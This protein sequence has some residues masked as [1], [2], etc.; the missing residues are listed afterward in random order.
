M[1]IS[2]L[3]QDLKEKALEYQRNNL[4]FDKESDSL[5][6]AFNWENTKEG[7]DFWRDLFL[8]QQKKQKTQL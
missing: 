8:K 1:K 7:P 4:S 5:V 6:Y 2:E 3:P